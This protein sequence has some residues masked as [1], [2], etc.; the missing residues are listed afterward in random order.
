MPLPSSCPIALVGLRSSPVVIALLIGAAAC[1][2]ADENT[3]STASSASRASTAS[4]ASTAPEAF[5]T[6]RPPLTYKDAK[7]LLEEH[8]TTCHA[9]GGPAAALPL[10][11]LRDVRKHRRHMITHIE[12]GSMPPGDPDFATSADGRK[13]LRWLKRGKEFRP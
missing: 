10:D 2:R 3:S 6:P 1:G 9:S 5:A 4:I 11:S 13:L 7:P 12:E 8:C